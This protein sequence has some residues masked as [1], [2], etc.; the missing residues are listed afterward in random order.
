MQGITR[1]PSL[2]ELKIIDQPPRRDA[3]RATS[4]STKDICSSGTIRHPYSS[5]MQLRHL[6]LAIYGFTISSIY[7]RVIQWEH[8]V[9]N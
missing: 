7:M 4:T 2:V 6:S 5:D 3:M 9:L 8:K 1:V